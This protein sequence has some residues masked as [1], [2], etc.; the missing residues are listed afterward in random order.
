MKTC[1]CSIR[2]HDG[3]TSHV[4][5]ARCNETGLLLL[6]L[7]TFSEDL[8]DCVRELQDHKN[9]PQGSKDKPR[10]SEDRPRGRPTLRSS[11]LTSKDKE[12]SES[13]KLGASCGPSNP[14][15]YLFR[16]LQAGRHGPHRAPAGTSTRSRGTGKRMFVLDDIRALQQA[17][18]PMAVGSRAHRWS[19]VPIRRAWT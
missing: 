1:T 12:G 3:S 6:C 9:R 16:T 18:G 2:N 15:A 5:L 14:A 10:A 11:A 19:Q 7:S 17:V 4:P 8:P 13:L